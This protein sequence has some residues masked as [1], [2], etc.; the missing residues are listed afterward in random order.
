MNLKEFHNN[1]VK[2]YSYETIRT[3][4]NKML[5]I[6]L[7]FKDFCERHNITY[8]L[9]SGTLL[10]AY[11][12]EGF[13]EWDD[14]VDICILKNDYDKL[15][16]NLSVELKKNN[17]YFL[18]NEWL[19]TKS[20]YNYLCTKKLFYIN[21]L[22]IL[23]PVKIDLLPVKSISREK[24]KA[25]DVLFEKASYY[26]KGKCY[27][28]KDL[29]N[30]L[31]K[32]SLLEQL[33]IKDEA[34]SHYLKEI[35]SDKYLDKRYILQK[36]HGNWSPLNYVDTET[37][38]PLNKIYFNE[39]EFPAPNN[40]KK[41][42]ATEYG[43]DFNNLPEISLRKSFHLGTVVL[44]NDQAIKNINISSKFD[45]EIFYRINRF[46]KLWFIIWLLKNK[47]LFLTISFIALKVLVNLSKLKT[48]L[49]D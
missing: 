11:R 2:F 18:Y 34:V 46:F 26:I 39:I 37:V 49:R 36:A 4:Q 1:G 42:L 38:F 9:D 31:N 24:N 23:K 47:G 16:S 12:N 41:Y 29:E 17:E 28:D 22:G 13:I 48:S 27:S 43:E 32:G 14:D 6:L 5:E 20:W 44:N 21:H 7:Y 15:I 45:N 8:W 19:N 25:E 10:G 35:N 30:K 40:V 33:R 3:H